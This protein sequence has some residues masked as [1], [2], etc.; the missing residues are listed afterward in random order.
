M[1]NLKIVMHACIIV[2]KFL[3]FLRTSDC[4]KGKIPEETNKHEIELFTGKK[5]CSCPT[6]SDFINGKKCHE[7]LLFICVMKVKKKK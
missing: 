5:C 4:F 6:S 2:H 3:V 1:R 7:A